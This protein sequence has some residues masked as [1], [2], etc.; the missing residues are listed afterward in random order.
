M[1]NLKFWICVLG[2]ECLLGGK[3]L[4]A[5]IDQYDCSTENDREYC[6]DANQRPVT[7]KIKKYQQDGNFES[8]VNYRNG[9]PDGLATY[10]RPEGKLKERV[11]YKQGIKNGMDKIYYE[12]RTIYQL[13]NYRNGILDGRQI[14]YTPNEKIFGQADYNEGVLKSG[15][16]MQYTGG[17]AKKRDFSSEEIKNMPYNQLFNC[18]AQ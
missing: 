15:F 7:G 1:K 14:F 6:V 2:L 4:C 17:K 11:Y 12:N 3:A 8:I 5:D 9:Y 13:L 10:F 16:C 18:E